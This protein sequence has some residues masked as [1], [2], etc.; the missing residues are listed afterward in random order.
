MSAPENDEG[1][2]AGSLVWVKQRGFPWWPS[3]VTYDPDAGQYSK[4]KVSGHR[5]CH[6]KRG[7]NSLVA[8]AGPF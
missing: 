7:Y 8:R 1:L 4:S 2:R 3:M 6:V 5:L